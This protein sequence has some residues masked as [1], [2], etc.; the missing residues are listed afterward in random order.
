LLE[1]AEGWLRDRRRD[2]MVGPMDFTT[3]DECGLLV[4]GYERKPLI[5]QGWHHRYYLPLLES[6]GLEKAMDLYMWELRLDR[7]EEKGGFHPMIQEAARKVREEHR[8][9]IRHMR[10]GDFEAELGR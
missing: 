8:V 6:Y 10:K 3:N 4:D 9:T 1:A 7:V 5:L 2:R